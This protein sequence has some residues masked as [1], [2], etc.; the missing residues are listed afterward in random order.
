MVAN[1]LRRDVPTLHRVAL[2]AV[3]PH[4]STVNIRVA[5]GAVLAHVSKNRLY[6]ALHA[7]H[8]FVHAPERVGRLVMVEFGHR[9]DR[10]PACRGVAVFTG[11]VQGAV[12]VPAG[13][14]LGR[15]R[16]SRRIRVHRERLGG[17][18]RQ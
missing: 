4:L 9:T 11:Y 15:G 7:F 17:G 14:L 2:G 12:R 18:K 8:F 5:I 6:V 3:G 16:Q 10:A 13:F 1:R